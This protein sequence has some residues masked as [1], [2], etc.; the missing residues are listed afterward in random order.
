M[1]LYLN[2]LIPQRIK[3]HPGSEIELSCCLDF[4]EQGFS[5]LDLSALD[6]SVLDVTGC[7]Y[8]L[9]PSTNQCMKSHLWLNFR[10]KYVMCLGL[11][12]SVE[13][14]LPNYNFLSALR[15]TGSGRGNA[16]V[17]KSHVSRATFSSVF[18]IFS[19]WKVSLCWI[20]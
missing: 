12:A 15:S 2:L 19:V 5:E 13:L 14:C 9:L 3:N 8:P 11:L 7:L 16:I 17:Y 18:L 4:N 20:F 10:Q 6:L 1:Y